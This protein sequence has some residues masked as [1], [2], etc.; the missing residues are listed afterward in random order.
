MY[1]GEHFQI[2]DI[3]AELKK[4]SN[5]LDVVNVKVINKSGAQYSNVQFSVDKNLS[6]EGAK[7]VCPKNA[8]FEIKFPAVDI[9]GKTR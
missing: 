3:Y 6:P 5:V 2:S 9:K 7:I 8:I 1:I 4:A